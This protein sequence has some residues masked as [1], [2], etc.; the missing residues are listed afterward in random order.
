MYQ[1]IYTFDYKLGKYEA[2]AVFKTWRDRIQFFF[3]TQS[4][5]FENILMMSEFLKTLT[6][7]SKQVKTSAFRT[8][9]EITSASCSN[10]LSS[11]FH[12]QTFPGFYP[13]DHHHCFSYTGVW[14][15]KVTFLLLF[16]K[17]LPGIWCKKVLENDFSYK[18]APATW[19]HGQ[20]L[21]TAVP[22]G[23]CWIQDP[24]KPLKKS[25]G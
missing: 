3:L 10:Y 4:I 12:Q 22:V 1:T 2:T 8:C 9:Y 21:A 15:G 24:V 18:R 23:K 6:F 11:T 13:A 16:D 25:R 14:E 7:P 5:I 19:L 20:A 17:V